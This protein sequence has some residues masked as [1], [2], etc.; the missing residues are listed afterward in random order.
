MA[1]QSNDKLKGLFQEVVK[2]VIRV[3]IAVDNLRSEILLYFGDRFTY[4]LPVNRDFIVDNWIVECLSDEDK[5]IVVAHN[6]FKGDRGQSPE[7]KFIASKAHSIRTKL[8]KWHAKIGNLIY[9]VEVVLPV[10]TPEPVMRSSIVSDETVK[11]DD[12]MPTPMSNPSITSGESTLVERELDDEFSQITEDLTYLSVTP[13]VTTAEVRIEEIHED[14]TTIEEVDC[15]LPRL[16]TLT[17]RWSA[18]ND[19]LDNGE[20][21]QDLFETQEVT[22]AKLWALL[23]SIEPVDKL[24][25]STFFEPCVG[26]GAITNFLRSVG[27]TEII[28][29]DLYTLPEKDDFFSTPLPEEYDLLV[30]NPPYGKRKKEFLEMCYA[31][32]KPFAVLLPTEVLQ[33]VGCSQVFREHGVL[34]GMCVPSPMF[35]HEGEIVKTT[36]TAWFLGNFGCVTPQQY[37]DHPAIVVVYL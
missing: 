3:E 26:H 4:N 22:V 23:Q 28:E 9:G 34:V 35:E 18:R 30:T 31:S 16:S 15:P 25:T 24:I 17:R 2:S 29:R 32:N 8:L 13:S 20:E 1:W 21:P 5:Q 10:P 6:E 33:H 14:N 11:Y 27:V 36:P 19:L 7:Q 37:L 12:V